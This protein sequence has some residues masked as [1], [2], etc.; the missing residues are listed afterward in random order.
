MELQEIEEI[1]EWGPRT[2]L[3]LATLTACQP[4]A[5][6][7]GAVLPEIRVRLQRTAK[8][9]DSGRVHE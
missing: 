2:F 3:S 8:G 1:A 9:A 7:A 6:S 4:V 5:S